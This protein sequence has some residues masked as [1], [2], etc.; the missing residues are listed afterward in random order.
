MSTM[1]SCPKNT[2]ATTHQKARPLNS[3]LMPSRALNVLAKKMFQNCSMMKKVKNTVFSSIVNGWNTRSSPI[4]SAVKYSPVPTTSAAM[5]RSMM[6]SVRRRGLLFITSLD[7]GREASAS[8]A[9]VSIMRFTH[10]IW[11]T[12]STGSGVMNAPI[13]T[14][15]QAV[16]FT[17]SWKR[18]KRCM[19]M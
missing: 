8:A 9:K 14:V 12:V 2:I 3:C 16:M 15:R 13:I 6:L 1:N 10:N 5:A 18:M 11:V 4:I 17:V 7:G 19:L